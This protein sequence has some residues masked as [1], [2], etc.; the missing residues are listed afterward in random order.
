[1]VAGMTPTTVKA[2]FISAVLEAGY[3]VELAGSGHYSPAAL[4]AKVAEIQGKI[5][6]GIGLILNS[7]YINPCQF[8][9][10]LPLW[11]D[12][13]REGLPIKGFCVAAGI[14][15]TEKAAEIISGLKSVGIRYVSFKLGSVDGIRQV[16]KTAAANLDFA[17]IMQWTGGHAGGHHSFEDFHQ[18]ILA[19]YSSIRRH[20]NISLV[21]GSGFGGS[22]DT[23]PYLTGDWSS[24][25]QSYSSLDKP[26]TFITSFFKK[27]PLATEQ[28][29]G[30]R[31]SH[32]SS[33]SRSARAKSQPHSS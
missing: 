9:F 2:G 33:T 7:L 12:M 28:L 20:D 21:A 23:W 16:V 18:P 11:Q 10:Q 29:L 31:I 1:M 30:P 13:R 3:H 19:T 8:S 25:L 17:I 27:Y 4:R 32:T 6:P 22:D 15:T 5:T 14:P 24:K 26:S